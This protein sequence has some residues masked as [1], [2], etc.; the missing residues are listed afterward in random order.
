MQKPDPNPVS[1]V[2]VFAFTL[3]FWVLVSA[4]KV[5]CGAQSLLIVGGHFAAIVLGLMAINASINQKTW[6]QQFGLLALLGGSAIL[7]VY[8][9]LVRICLT[10]TRLD[11]LG[12]GGWLALVAIASLIGWS[13]ITVLAEATSTMV[14]W[15]GRRRP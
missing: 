1:F 13:L 3:I 4:A 2:G 7:A 14:W 10:P 9:S 15:L 11:N 12:I 5:S 8:C 6:Q